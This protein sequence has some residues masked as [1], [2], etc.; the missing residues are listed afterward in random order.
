MPPDYAGLRK[1]LIE[2]ARLAYRGWNERRD[3]I[4]PPFAGRLPLDDVALDRL[5]PETDEDLV[6]GRLTIPMPDR[7]HSFLLLPP[8]EDKPNLACVLA[9]KWRF[10][11]T[12]NRGTFRLFM[13][14]L[15]GRTP[16]DTSPEPFIIRFDD[17][18]E[19]AGWPFAHVQVSDRAQPYERLF[20]NPSAWVP[21]EVPRMPLACTDCTSQ[22][23]FVCVIAGLYGVDSTVFKRVVGEMLDTSAAMLAKQL[24]RNE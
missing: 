20:R 17:A 10:G 9:I 2:V 7:E 4:L 1:T 15:G 5:L 12:A 8:I 24:S 6:D 22:A 13:L 23:M 16:P 18:E 3:E 14:P 21:S 19:G 11:E